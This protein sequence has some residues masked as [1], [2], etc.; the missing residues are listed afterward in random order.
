MKKL[1]PILLNLM[2]F[3]LCS[4]AFAEDSEDSSNASNPFD[5][6]YI[7]A[8]TGLQHQ[9][10]DSNTFFAQALLLE[11]PGTLARLQAPFSFTSTQN[12]TNNTFDAGIFTGWGKTLQFGASEHSKFYFGGELYLRDSPSSFSYN[13][14][15]YTSSADIPLNHIDFSATSSAHIS[16]DLSFGG[17]LRFGYLITNQIMLYVL[18][19]VEST[20]FDDTLTESA[21]ATITTNARLAQFTNTYQLNPSGHA[22]QYQTAFMP[23]IG[24][25]A[26]LTDNLSIRAQYTY[27][28]YGTFLNYSKDTSGPILPMNLGPIENATM[29]M[30]A[31]SSDKLSLNRNLFTLGLTYHFNNL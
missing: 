15:K 8:D 19:G 11:I 22:H 5:G 30:T 4:N 26:M 21:I 12:L 27:V 2:I 31:I 10:G 7:G 14:P 29:L 25:E 20:K 16:S 18:A 9:S 28:N 1:L 17:D 24:L 3:F 13:N 6:F 23:G